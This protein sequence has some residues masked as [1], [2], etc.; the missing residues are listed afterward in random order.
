VTFYDGSKKVRLPVCPDGFF[1]VR[2]TNRPEPTNRLSFALE[3][4]RSTTTRRT[5]ND[6]LRAYCNYLDQKKQERK[7][8]VRWF[9]VVTV[10]LTIARADS[11][12]ALAREA[13]PTRLQKFFLF[14]SREHFSLDAPNLVF[15]EIYHTPKDDE[16]ISLA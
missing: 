12:R 3:A 7:F 1:T 4:D 6:K 14:T 10:T 8:N 11:L 5:F 9:R 13:I 15:Y 2:N 16:L